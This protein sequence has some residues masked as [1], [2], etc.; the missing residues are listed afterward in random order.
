M[1]VWD[2]PGLENLEG[3]P[4]VKKITLSKENG[5]IMGFTAIK[6]SGKICF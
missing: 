5:N 3:L 1:T 2:L 4:T 6:M